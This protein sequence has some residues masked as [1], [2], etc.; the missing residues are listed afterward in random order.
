MA[1]FFKC[2]NVGGL[3]LI[4]YV[5]PYYTPDGKSYYSQ[6]WSNEDFHAYELPRV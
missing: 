3:S 6:L 4:T 1:L 2:L 5:E